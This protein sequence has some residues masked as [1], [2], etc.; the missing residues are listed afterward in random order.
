MSNNFCVYFHINK[1]TGDVYYIGSG[2]SGKREIHFNGRSKDWER[3]HSKFGTLVSIY[4]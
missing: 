2:V 3:I 4:I 1:E